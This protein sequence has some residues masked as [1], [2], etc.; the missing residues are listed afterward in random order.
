MD[1]KPGNPLKCWTSLTQ[2][3]CT[4]Y[5]EAWVVGCSWLEV[6]PKSM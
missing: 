5:S 6:F 1:P 2:L 4:I 3:F